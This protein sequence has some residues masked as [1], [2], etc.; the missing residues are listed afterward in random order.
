MSNKLRSQRD[1][2]GKNFAESSLA[3]YANKLSGIGNT[4]ISLS[5]LSYASGFIIINI[6]L[7][8]KYGIY[9]FEI[10]NA[11]YIYS[12]ASFL[13]MCLVAYLGAL[14][15]AN[16]AEKRKNRSWF[17]KISDFVIWFG[18]IN[19]LDA[20][21]IQGVILIAD[22]SGLVNLPIFIPGINRLTQGC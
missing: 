1:E 7:A 8:N 19:F 5:G 22:S 16:R 15:L 13:M 17:E 10:F 6:Y 21:I 20:V 18:I 3:D 12:G 9:S 11:R 2:R 14:Y 4:F